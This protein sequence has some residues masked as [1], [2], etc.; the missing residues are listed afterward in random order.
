MV[1]SPSVNRPGNPQI[2]PSPGAPGSDPAGTTP[3]QPGV[4]Q[5]AMTQGLLASLG[6]GGPDAASQPRDVAGTQGTDPARNPDRILYGS[7]DGRLDPPSPRTPDRMTPAEVDGASSMAQEVQDALTRVFTA[8]YGDAHGDMALE[9]LK[10][11][12]MNALNDP[13]TMQEMMAVFEE[14]AEMVQQIADQ[15]AEQAIQKQRE[16][17]ASANESKGWGIFGMI[18][19]VIVAVVLTAVT[20]GAAAAL[21]AVAVIVAIAI[22]G[23]IIAETQGGSFGDGFMIGAQIGAALVSIV[24]SFGTNAGGYVQLL[25]AIAAIAQASVSAATAVTQYDAAMAAADAQEL[26]ILAEFFRGMA[27]R[28]LENND[29]IVKFLQAIQESVS[30]AFDDA[31]GA[32]EQKKQAMGA[33]IAAGAV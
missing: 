10:L 23:G 4:D 22:I 19:A 21:I 18:L 25:A 13:T 16:A 28:T 12:I 31:Q 20:F 8:T 3:G 9:M 33:V 2:P 26:E 29:D 5:S 1:S 17:E 6:L 7:G 32:I 27:D 15:K 24:C 11:R 14:I 30:A